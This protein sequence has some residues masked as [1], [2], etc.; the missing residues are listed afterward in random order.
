MASRR[1]SSGPVSLMIVS[2][3][4]SSRSFSSR[5]VSITAWIA[6]RSLGGASWSR[7]QMSMNEGMGTWRDAMHL[8]SVVFP[9]PFWAITPYR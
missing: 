4:F 3:S 2:S 7:Y 6:V 8:S 5:T 9:A 1:G